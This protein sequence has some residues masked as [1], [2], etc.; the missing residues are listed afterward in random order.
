MTEWEGIVRRAGGPPDAEFNIF[1]EEALA[2][3]DGKVVPL[4]LEPGG[5]VIGEATLKYD[6][7]EKTLKTSFRVDDPKLAELLKGTPPNIFG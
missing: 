2:A 1:T 6:S 4:T 7:N 5:P 3:Q